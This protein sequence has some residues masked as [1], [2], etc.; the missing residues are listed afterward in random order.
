MNQKPREP[1]DTSKDHA[2]SYEGSLQEK[3][4][5]YH[6]NES[7][8]EFVADQSTMTDQEISDMMTRLILRKMIT[9]YRG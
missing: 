5:L 2:L 1:E 7:F 8:M 6:D 9:P 4:D 3:Q